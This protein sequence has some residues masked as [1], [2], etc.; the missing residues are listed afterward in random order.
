MEGVLSDAIPV[1]WPVSSDLKSIPDSLRDSLFPPALLADV[2]SALEDA[3]I[4]STAGTTGTTGTTGGSGG[5]TAAAAAAAQLGERAALATAAAAMMA[6]ASSGDSYSPL[7]SASS[8]DSAQAV[9]ALPLTKA[10]KR[11]LCRILRT[12]L[13]GWY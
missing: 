8:A 9:V 12:N 1:Q 11:S 7:G 2:S 6:G 5:T 13:A 10:E 4:A 3:L